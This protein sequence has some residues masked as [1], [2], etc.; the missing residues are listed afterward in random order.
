MN[1]TRL[2]YYVKITLYNSIETVAVLIL[3]LCRCKKNIYGEKGNGGKFLPIEILLEIAMN[4]VLF[5]KTSILYHK[6]DMSK[7]TTPSPKTTVTALR[8]NYFTI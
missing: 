7:G 4:N 1:A 6:K 5:I 2:A 3:K 8:S